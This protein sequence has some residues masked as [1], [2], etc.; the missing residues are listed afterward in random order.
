M[1]ALSHHLCVWEAASQLKL[2]K[3]DIKYVLLGDDIAFGNKALY[4]KYREI[5][6][7]IGIEFSE[8]KTHESLTLM[9]FAKR[10]LFNKEE[11]TQFPL[12]ALISTINR[13]WEV[14]PLFHTL[15]TRDSY[16]MIDCPSMVI[17]WV[18]FNNIRRK[19][20]PPK[21]I[22]TNLSSYTKCIETFI[23]FNQKRKDPIDLAHTLLVEAGYEK[24]WL[25]MEK[26][27]NLFKGTLS[28]LLADSIEKWED[29][30]YYDPP[31]EDYS[32]WYSST[33]RHWPQDPMFWSY[34][35]WGH[36][37]NRIKNAGS[38][39]QL[40]ALGGDGLSS[41]WGQGITNP[42]LI[43]HIT[44]PMLNTIFVSRSY[45]KILLIIASIVKKMLKFLKQPKEYL[46]L[47]LTVGAFKSYLLESD[48]RLK[49]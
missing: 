43:K 7:S 48:P 45:N 14:L 5:I 41:W 21:K 27:N 34:L 32:M 1:L 44:V 36:V 20:F 38:Q 23:D 37:Y 11:I 12:N 42:D 49:S 10:W 8:P 17:N 2:H 16:R 29:T 18:N 35:P 40:R 19:S 22:I 24:T 26:S 6:T 46:G 39:L 33:L 4:I 25:P 3:K 28:I 13:W 9:E 31:K 15:N 47:A 30:Q